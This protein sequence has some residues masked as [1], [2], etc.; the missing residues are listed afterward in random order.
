MNEYTV[1]N[2]DVVCALK[3]SRKYLWNGREGRDFIDTE[4]YICFC[5]K[6]A[7]DEGKITEGV[8]NRTQLIIQSRIQSVFATDFDA[9]LEY[10][11][12]AQG[13][14]QWEVNDHPRMQA[15][16]KKWLGMLIREFSKK[17]PDQSARLPRHA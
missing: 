8:S 12:L 6:L 4:R 17:N 1:T 2:A 13:V 11:L 7:E 15:Y 14:P 5:M 9:S 10:W 3:A 16:R